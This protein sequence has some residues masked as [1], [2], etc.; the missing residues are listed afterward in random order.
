MDANTS[1]GHSRGPDY[2]WQYSC[3]IIMDIAVI[4]SMDGNTPCAIVMDIAV[5]M[6]VGGNTSCAIIMDVAVAV[7]MGTTPYVQ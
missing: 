2:G 7:S 5:I 6:G 4:L 1:Y 3:A